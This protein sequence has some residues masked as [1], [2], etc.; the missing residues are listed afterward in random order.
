MSSADVKQPWWMWA[1]VLLMG[2]GL[3]LL[4]LTGAPPHRAPGGGEVQ[5]KGQAMLHVYVQREAESG[6]NE[7]VYRHLRLALEG[8]AELDTLHHIEF[9]QDIRVDPS[10]ESMRRDPTFRS[11]LIEYYGKDSPLQ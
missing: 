10:F 3:Y 8:M 5:A 2:V 9:R 6:E 7:L 4:N 11:I 1:L